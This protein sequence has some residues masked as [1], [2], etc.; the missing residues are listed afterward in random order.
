MQHEL[1]QH[2]MAAEV[3]SPETYYP[4]TTRL[5]FNKCEECFSRIQIRRE[6]RDA[7]SAVI[8]LLVT[9]HVKLCSGLLEEMDAAEP[10]QR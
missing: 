4:L 1:K 7:R 9:C 3:S 8:A 10:G 5:Q 2:L 6:H